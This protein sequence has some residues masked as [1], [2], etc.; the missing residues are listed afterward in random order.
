MF[1]VYIFCSVVGI[2]LLLLFALG[3]GDVEGEVGFDAELEADFGADFGGELDVSGADAGFG[4]ASALRRIPI[5]SYTSFVAFFGGVGVVSTLLGVGSIATL[6]LAIVLGFFAAGVNTAL[7]SFLRNTESDS[8]ITDKQLEGRIAV[9]SVPIEVGKRGRVTLDTGGERMQL[10]A[11]SVD[12]MGDVGFAR[13]DEVVIVQ[14]VGG[15]AEVMSV[16][17]ELRSNG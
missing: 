2:P 12:A 13:G 3:G 9:V 8:S 10:T 1:A 11:G 15:V 14:V 17:P 16:D 5:S 4:D 6:V 7:F